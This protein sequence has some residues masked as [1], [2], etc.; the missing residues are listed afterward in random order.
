[1]NVTV[2]RLDGLRRR[3][4][5][6]V[7]AERVTE[8]LDKVAKLVSK[9]V[10]VPGGYRDPKAKLARVRQILRKEIL[11]QTAH[12][13]VSETLPEAIEQ[14]GLAG[15]GTP[16]V[17]DES[18]ILAGA[19]FRYVVEL[20]VKPEL[21]NVR[22]KGMALP[23]FT[24]SVSNED[25]DRA[26][27]E[28]RQ[29]S[30]QFVPAGTDPV[31]V[32]GAAVV[33]WIPR[34]TDEAV[35]KK[36]SRKKVVVPM[37]ERLCPEPLR[38]AL[39][40]RR[41]GEK[42]EVEVPVALMPGLAKDGGEGKYVWAMELVDAYRAR[43]PELNDQFAKETRGLSSVLALRGD[44]R[45]ELTKERQDESNRRTDSLL[46]AELIAA[47]PLDVPTGVLTGIFRNRMQTIRDGLEKRYGKELEMGY[48]DQFVEMRSNEELRA[49]YREVALYFIHDAIAEA[50]GVTVEESEVETELAKLARQE[51]VAPDFLKSKYGKE[52]IE[53]V[54][55]RLR[56]ERVMAAV[57]KSGIVVNGDSYIR[58]RAY[59]FNVRRVVRLRSSGAV[60][61]RTRGLHARGR[62]C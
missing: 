43:I 45:E 13:L 41:V 50:E 4:T 34:T 57:R 62:A 6:E 8:S 36:L 55:F 37:E 53:A 27:E 25:V 19:P 11:E 61:R 35:V 51:G 16:E 60:L 1:M 44:I 14:Q 49:S 30:A 22:Y 24:T 59:S 54:R 40:G 52:G 39:L 7:P 29:Q 20:E 9:N 23:V 28:M 3:V 26:L 12:S 32:G 10:N 42:F 15:V 21:S 38:T 31:E 17:T 46:E 48:L 58:R 47:N 2:E 5:V 56:G 18:P 33:D